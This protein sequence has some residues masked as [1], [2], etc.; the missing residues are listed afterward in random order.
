MD[1]RLAPDRYS[2]TFMKEAGQLIGQLLGGKYRVQELLALGGMG[3]VYAA[4]H[5][6]TGRAVA[7]KLLRPE[8]AGRPDLVDGYHRGSARGR[9]LSPQRGGGVGWGR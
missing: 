3:F 4:R 7:L 2:L 8:L 5:E 6:V 9:S 1:D